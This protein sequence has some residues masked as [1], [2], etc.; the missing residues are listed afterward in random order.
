MA[1]EFEKNEPKIMHE[2]CAN[3]EKESL[4]GQI[5]D[6]WYMEFNTSQPNNRKPNE[7]KTGDEKFHNHHLHITIKE[8]GIYE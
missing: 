3:V 5:L 8:P 1:K 4:V 2:L 6:P 7:Q